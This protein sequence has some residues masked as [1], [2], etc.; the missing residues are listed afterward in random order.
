MKKIIELY[1]KY[2]EIVN[3]L[4]AGVLTTI[5]G[6]LSFEIFL[7]VFHIHYIISN[8]LSW[9][10]AVS[11]AYVINRRFVFDSKTEGKEQFK[12]IINFFK[13]RLVSL[14]IET[15]CLYLLVDI[16]KFDASISKIFM[17]V[18]VVILNYVFSKFFTFKK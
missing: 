1:K 3:Y 8:V 6:L 5:V 10:T 17:Q 16:C 4:I 15:G 9:I 18:V 2:K 14:V 13:Y 12:E 7:K 11:F